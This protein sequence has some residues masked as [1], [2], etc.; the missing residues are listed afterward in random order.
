MNWSAEQVAII[1]EDP[2]ARLLVDAGPGTGKTAVLGARIAYIAENFGADSAN[3]WVVSFTRTAVAELRQRLR[4]YVQDRS[5]LANIRTFTLDSGAWSINAG[6]NFDASLGSGFTRN[7]K[8][9]I[10]LIT[11][12]DGAFDY[13]RTIDHLFIDEGQDIVGVR[14]ELVMEMLN[15][16]PPAAGVTVFSDDA[17][18][19]YGDWSVDGST[20]IGGTLPQ[21]IRRYFSDKYSLHSLTQNFRA[22]DENLLDLYNT[23][24]SLVLSDVKG[25]SKYRGV[26]NA[27]ADYAKKTEQE[28]LSNYSCPLQNGLVLGRTRL[29]ALTE[30]FNHRRAVF[31]WRMTGTPPLVQPWIGALLWDYNEKFLIRDDFLTLWSVRVPPNAVWD[32]DIAWNVL[33]KNFGADGRGA[34]IDLDALS[35]AIAGMFPPLEICNPNFG[36]DGP[37]LG[38]IHT[39]KG[40]EADEVL[41]KLPKWPRKGMPDDYYA[42]EA[43]VLFVGAS[44]ARSRLKVIETSEAAGRTNTG[45]G[46]TYLEVGERLRDVHI[47][48]GKNGDILPTGMA[49]REFMSAREATDAQKLLTRTMNAHQIGSL[50][51][52]KNLV[53]GSYHW[54]LRCGLAPDSNLACMSRDFLWDLKSVPKSYGYK[55]HSV[56]LDDVSILGARTMALAPQDPLRKELLVPF[57]RTGI[58]LAPVIAAFPL[59]GLRT[60]PTVFL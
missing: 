48:V 10:S 7:I 2:S 46:R 16:L 42:E 43:R 58:F 28:S 38:T 14:A 12:H 26:R 22:S 59:L 19:I 40:R 1:R 18:A 53:S 23:C 24:R 8:E 29:A 36:F 41:L 27:I 52:E 37:I 45:S 11:R 35:C 20:S 3:I 49:G 39:S 44:R 57:N 9:V 21:N 6:F 50:F 25:E 17:Q 60:S 4:N 15:L 32:P 56:K 33:F 54:V 13:L 47:E 30:T 5:K 55:G 51:Y 31:Q 34:S